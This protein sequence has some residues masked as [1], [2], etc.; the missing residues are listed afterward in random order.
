M[1]K[2]TI[3]RLT[4]PHSDAP[5]SRKFPELGVRVTHGQVYPLRPGGTGERYG[6]LAGARAGISGTGVHDATA[7]TV[8][9]LGWAA[10]PS[11][12][13]SQA[14]GRR[15]FIAFADGRVHRKNLSGNRALRAAQREIEQFNT[16]A[17]GLGSISNAS[18]QYR[19]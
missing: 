15:V 10:L 19:L 3:E 6:P 11:V 1:R 13:K 7:V 16:L 9:G 14:G 5:A 4:H 2:I 18:S 12:R 8:V 17:A